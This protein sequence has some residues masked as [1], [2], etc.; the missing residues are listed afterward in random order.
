[1]H[2]PEELEEK[3]WKALKDDRTLMLGLDGVEDGHA[4]PM[5][6]QYEQVRGPL[7]F[8]TSGDNAL[9]RRLGS[10]GSQRAIAAFVAKDH[11][12]FASLQGD[13]RVD[14]DRAVVERLW[15]PFVAA[16]YEGK[17]DP[18]L[19][20]LRLDAGHAEIWLNANSLLAGVKMLFGSDP[21]QDYKDNGARVDLH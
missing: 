6:A 5:T 16:W 19:R 17:D 10:G 3:L 21:K 4:R 20:L 11:E 1:M 18:K 9:V 15:N 14:A 13:L 8:F 2:S 7:W 12:I